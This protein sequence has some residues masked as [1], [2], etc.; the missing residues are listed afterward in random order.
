LASFDSG[1]A[2]DPEQNEFRRNKKMQLADFLRSYKR[3]GNFQEFQEE[4]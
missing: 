3:Q 1:V 2:E 4:E